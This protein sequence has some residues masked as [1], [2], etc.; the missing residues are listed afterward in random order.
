MV[1][2]LLV[3]CGQDA[4]APASRPVS[5]ADAAARLHE[6]GTFAFDASFT[7]TKAGGGPE[8]YMSAEG[9]VDLSSG[10]GRMDLDLSGVLG[11]PPAGEE[12]PLAGPFALAW[13]RR[14]LT[15][16][17]GAGTQSLPR[18]EAREDA[19]LIGRMPYEVEALIEL[20]D[21]AGGTR[22]VGTEEVAGTPTTRLSFTVDARTAGRRGVPAEL[23]P[24]F[25]RGLYGPRLGL[26]T[27]VDA[28][29]LPHRIR[30]LLDLEPVR[31]QG[32]QVLPRRT[33]QGT[34]DLHSFGRPLGD[35]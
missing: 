22:V 6:A 17:T 13:D 3:G 20:L 1:A 7:R 32:R 33:I 16:R 5:P 18:G 27:W 35:G 11:T 30:Y 29:G 25:E 34:Y 10:A 15:A 31:A 21:R 2:A 24:A 14:T 19:G 12:N 23:S 8:E 4:A 28:D 26:E 9:A